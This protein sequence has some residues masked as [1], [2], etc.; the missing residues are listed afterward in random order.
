MRGLLC[1]EVK[2]TSV[3]QLVHGAH[4]ILA[5]ALCIPLSVVSP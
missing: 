5:L 1:R 2:W 3:S 4:D